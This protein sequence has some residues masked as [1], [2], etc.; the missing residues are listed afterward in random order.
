MCSNRESIERAAYKGG[1]ANDIKFLH[2]I[3]SDETLKRSIVFVLTP[4]S[5]DQDKTDSYNMN[6][7]AYVFK[8]EVEI[9]L[10][11]FVLFVDA[12]RKIAEF[13]PQGQGLGFPCG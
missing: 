2:A 9:G 1:R 10:S 7:S 4:F 3:R 11:Q 13:P 6:V 12:Y 8:D 5:M